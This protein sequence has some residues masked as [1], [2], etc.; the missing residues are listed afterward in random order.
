MVKTKREK[1]R[2]KEGGRKKEKGFRGCCIMLTL[3]QAN[4]WTSAS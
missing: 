2:W 1:R 3:S 4:P